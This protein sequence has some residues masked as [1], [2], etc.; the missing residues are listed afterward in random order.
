MSNPLLAIQDL[1]VA[2]RDEESLRAVVNGVSF[3]IDQGET[4]AL[5]GESGSGKS[6][7]A[8]S[9]LRLLPPHKVC[10]PGGAIRYAGADLL[11][12][13]ERQLREIRGNRI[14]MVFQEPMTSLNPLHTLEKQIGE[15]LRLHK[16][17]SGMA[18]RTRIVE[19]LELVG[20]DEPASRLRS[21]PHELSGGQ[22]Q[23]VM[24]AMALA[25]EPQLLIADE[26][27][28]A[29]DV[30]VQLKILDLLKDLQQRLGMALLL[31]SHDLN[32]VRRIADRVCVMRDGRIVEQNACEVLFRQPQHAYT[33]QLLDAEPNQA[34]VE[35]DE[36]AAPLLSVENLRVQFSRRGGWLGR[37]SQPL[38]AVDGVGFELRRGQTL[39]VVG[40]SGSGKSTLGLAILRL[41]DSQGGIRFD[42]QS[43]D[44]LS[45]RQV[46]PW[47]RQIQVVFQDPYGSLSPRMSVA[48]IIGE[49]LSIH[50]IGNAQ[51]REASII[52]A[53]RE[54]GLDPQ[55]RHRYPHEF[56]G[57][58][59]QRI[60]IARAL[61]LKPQLILL[62]EPTSALDRTVQRQIVELLRRLQQRH[63][64]SYLFISHDLAV[65]KALSHRLLIMR[66]GVAVE[67]GDA[68]A[69]FAAPRHPYTRALLEAAFQPPASQS[70][71]GALHV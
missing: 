65:V 18:A 60:A 36:V 44:C 1:H 12:C 51:E 52:E 71:Q 4:L 25:C 29:L 27:T 50:G 14:A 38:R 11:H 21:Y 64:L 59:R 43:L 9:I 63:G 32:L 49:G 34:P 62:D 31:I 61:V 33:Q 42:G 13:S 24:I 54:V 46:R 70:K 68:A 5:V 7:T 15:V 17:Q 66:G 22:R 39:G 57:G 37:R 45:K 28:T 3:S 58:Q 41:I 48:Q 10:Y 23:R 26:P 47:R 55:S 19:L 53:L 6:V 8:Q 30:T 69:I 56:S 35:R 16:N 20:I 40:E 2:F 67:Q